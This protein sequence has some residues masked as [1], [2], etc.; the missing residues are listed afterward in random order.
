MSSHPNLS[1]IRHDLANLLIRA[2]LELHS[3]LKAQGTQQT[4][5]GFYCDFAADPGSENLPRISQKQFPNFESRMRDLA[6][7]N[8]KLIA[9]AFCLK[10]VSGAQQ[11]GESAGQLVSRIYVWAYANSAEL[12]NAVAQS[13][14]MAAS[15]HRKIGKELELF[16]FDDE[17]GPGLPLWLP[18]GVVIRDELEKYMKELEFR[19]LYQRVST[20]HIARGSLYEL[21]G[22]LE[23]FADSMFPPMHLEEG[24]PAKPLHLRE[25]YYLRPMNC[26]HHHRI[27][28]SR[29]RSYRELPMRLAEYGQVYR[30]EDSGALLGLMRARACCQ[31]DAHIYCS[32]EQLK[33]E[34]LA[35]IAMYKEA[36]AL[37]GISEFRMRLSKWDEA[38]PKRAKKYADAPQL[39]EWAQ[40]VLREVLIEAEI[41]FFESIGEAAFYG[42][43]ID[44]QFKS[45]SGKEET[46]STIQLDFSSA[47]K[48]DLAYRGRDGELHRPLIIHRAPLGSHERLVAFLLEK[49]GGAFPFWLS[50]VQVCFLPVSEAHADLAQK[51][52][53]ELRREFFRV[54]IKPPSESL[55]KRMRLAADV[56]TPFVV[57]IGE[58]ERQGDSISF[59]K[60]GSRAQQQM[61]REEFFK[62]L[63]EL[64]IKRCT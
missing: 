12:E 20:P 30:Y 23:H 33:G 2:V 53:E 48:M 38:D 8:E 51:L 46:A 39:W 18:N 42:P 1:E 61:S 3:N 49:F 63:S 32:D 11:S 37:L 29:P 57:I 45:Q 35:I 40:G 28:A 52:V 4:D 43:K 56:K 59:R 50:P 62:L 44:I 10:S 7:F 19:G 16:A 17:V 24:G 58:K 13:A 27:F 36:Y 15:D 22:H 64:R 41:E 55:A 34:L 25:K 26:P 6:L 21:S 54:E 14:V 47:A 31:N 5:V 9:C 60:H